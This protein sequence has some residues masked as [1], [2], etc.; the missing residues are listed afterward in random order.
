[1]SIQD[2]P[3]QSVRAYEPSVA[4][5]RAAPGSTVTILPRSESTP[6]GPLADVLDAR[7]LER[8][9]IRPG[10]RQSLPDPA[11]VQIVIAIGSDTLPGAGLQSSLSTEV[12][13]LRRADAAGASILGIGTGAQ[14]L[15]LAFGGTTERVR[16]PQ[17]GW[18]W[19]ETAE[20]ELVAPGPW[21]AWHHRTVLLP[22][23]AEP[24]ARD[25]SGPQ[26]FR[27][28]QHLGIHFH[29]EV[30]PEVLSDWV[31]SSNHTGLDTQGVLEAAV[32]DFRT[33]A[34]NAYRLFAAFIASVGLPPS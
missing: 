30:T 29:P 28:G 15:A 27:L 13:W 20:A 22:R 34:A 6:L 17:H 21:L 8:D 19:V 7:G 33:M 16:S 18:T 31:L 4:P 1:M 9:T 10:S 23:A 32:R 25:A 26:A 14:T 3:Q 2:P 5:S 12:D 11:S 24:I